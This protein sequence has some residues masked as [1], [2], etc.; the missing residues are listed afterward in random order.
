MRVIIIRCKPRQEAATVS[1]IMEGIGTTSVNGVSPGGPSHPQDEEMHALKISDLATPTT[2]DHVIS[3][4]HKPSSQLAL[5]Q[6]GQAGVKLE[7]DQCHKEPDPA[8]VTPKVDGGSDSPSEHASASA[9]APHKSTVRG[10]SICI[11]CGLFTAVFSP[12]FSLSTSKSITVPPD[13]TPLSTWTA[14]FFFAIAFAATSWTLNLSIL[15]RDK[16]AKSNAIVNWAALPRNVHI[17][18]V[19]CGI[20]CGLAMLQR[21]S[22]CFL[23]V[24]R[25]ASRHHLASL[26]YARLLASDSCLHT[27]N[28]R[29]SWLYDI[30]IYICIL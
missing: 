15:S 30:H 2:H 11:L 17:I 5:V 8:G 7:A 27:S 28:S 24:H 9:S 21:T 1:N 3:D 13:S 6:N 16:T 4:V 10:V 14:F 20:L 25:L 22:S 23:V 29:I 19:V 26:W 12:L 18:C